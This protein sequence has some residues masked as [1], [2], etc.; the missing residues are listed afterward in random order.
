MFS[1]NH[2]KYIVIPQRTLPKI[3]MNHKN[4]TCLL[5][6]F[7]FKVQDTF[8]LQSGLM[9]MDANAI[10]KHFLLRSP[11]EEDQEKGHQATSG[12]PWDEGPVMAVPTLPQILQVVTGQHLAPRKRPAPPAP[13]RPP[14][15][16]SG[17]VTT[18]SLRV[19]LARTVRFGE[20]D[21][22]PDRR[23]RSLLPYS[24]K[25]RSP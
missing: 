20:D 10:H 4:H 19:R 17:L 15:R 13:R 16:R 18:R 5:N 3:E 14:G 25:A 7:R 23:Q 6:T 24:S 21:A 2:E 1:W 9:L 12:A 11:K 22:S 8:R